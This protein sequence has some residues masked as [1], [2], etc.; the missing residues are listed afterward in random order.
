MKCSP[1][2]AASVKRLSAEMIVD[3]LNEA[4]RRTAEAQRI[5]SRAVGSG[6]NTSPDQ[7]RS[8]STLKPKFT[9]AGLNCDDKHVFIEGQIDIALHFRKGLVDASYGSID[10]SS[11]IS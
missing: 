3:H 8:N 6:C 5:A 10:Q 11:P 2:T 1:A 9:I 7:I 4:T